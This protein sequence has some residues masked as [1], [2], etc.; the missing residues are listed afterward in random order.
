MINLSMVMHFLGGLGLF[1]Y[2]V[3]TTSGGLQK[4]AA[5]KLKGILESLTKKTWTAT[6][7]GIGM[8]VAL[9]SS[10]ATTVMV[11]EFVNAGLMT[12]V[13]A[14]G[15]SLGS[16]VGTSIVIQL[17]SFPILDI[18]LL[19]LGNWLYKIGEH[20]VSVAKVFRN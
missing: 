11:V 15:V 2:G 13:Q 20:M 12:L 8:T 14:L 4:I 16:A 6:L 18:A 10:A 9:Q 7:F 17:I 1:L 3:H 5:N 19:E